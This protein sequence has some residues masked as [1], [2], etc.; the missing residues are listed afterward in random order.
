MISIFLTTALQIAV[1]FFT[2]FSYFYHS[3]LTYTGTPSIPFTYNYVYTT[4][5]A[6][7][8][9]RDALHMKAGQICKVARFLPQYCRKIKVMEHKETAMSLRHMYAYFV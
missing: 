5:P 7:H 9:V 3:T 6:T 4:R 2:L 1:I 8:S